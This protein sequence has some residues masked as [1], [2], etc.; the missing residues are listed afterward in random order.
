MSLETPLPFLINFYYIFKK[1]VIIQQ[2][3]DNKFAAYEE[4]YLS[5]Q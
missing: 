3:L 4:N 2:L 5:Q 1:V